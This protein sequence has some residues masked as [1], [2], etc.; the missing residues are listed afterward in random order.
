VQGAP[1]LRERP[2][3]SL[4]RTLNAQE[5]RPRFELTS[6]SAA[7]RSAPFSTKYC[8][9]QGQATKLSMFPSPHRLAWG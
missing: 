9:C 7:V 2:D 6:L 8:T 4:A 3:A 1:P 5:A